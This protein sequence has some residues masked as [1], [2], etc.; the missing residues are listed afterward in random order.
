MDKVVTDPIRQA[1]LLQQLGFVQKGYRL[2]TYVEIVA[3]YQ[4][5]KLPESEFNHFLQEEG[6]GLQHPA[7][8]S[9]LTRHSELYAQSGFACAAMLTNEELWVRE[10]RLT[11][12]ELAKLLAVGFYD[13]TE[14]YL[15]AGVGKLN[16]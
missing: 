6:T 9:V 12:R 3:A 16:H 11:D 8:Q 14:R 1:R 2:L 13:S 5:K 4:M 15:E 10:V 7:G